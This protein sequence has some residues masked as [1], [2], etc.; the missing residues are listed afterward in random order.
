MPRMSARA[1][2]FRLI[3]PS[4]RYS[5]MGAAVSVNS[6]IL[7]R[8]P[9]KPTPPAREPTAA[10]RAFLLPPDDHPPSHQE[11]ERGIG[12]QVALPQPGGFLREPVEPFQAAILH[13][14]RCHSL[15]AGVEIERS[16]DA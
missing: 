1:R 3:A 6:R 14:L 7:Q 13:P 10:P 5:R 2:N 9:G 11:H 16:A 15:F 4:G 12:D 8:V